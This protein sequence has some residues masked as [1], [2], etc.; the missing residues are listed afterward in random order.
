MAL[1]REQI[2]EASQNLPIRKV[3]TPEWGG[4]GHVYVRMLRGRDIDTVHS[5]AREMRARKDAGQSPGEDPHTMAAWVIM[6]A[7]SEDGTPLFTKDDAEWLLDGPL[8]PLR[9]CME[10]ALALNGIGGD[11][12]AEGNSDSSPSE[13]SPTG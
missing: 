7:C 5:T 1:T 8:A 10:E 13:S 3:S 9:R 4:D 6:A 2:Q 12:E 11:E